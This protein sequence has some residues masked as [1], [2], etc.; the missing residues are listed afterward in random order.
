MWYIWL[1]F[2]LWPG[3]AGL[4]IELAGWLVMGEAGGILVITGWVFVALR[5]IS[6][7]IFFFCLW[8]QGTCVQGWKQRVFAGVGVRVL[9][10]FFLLSLSAY[11][12][13]MVGLQIA[14]FVC[15]KKRI[16]LVCF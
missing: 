14:N 8:S 12:L 5:C 16:I 4:F 3:W 2:F 11:Q 10:H 13:D 7:V 1:L 9:Y 15:E 6:F